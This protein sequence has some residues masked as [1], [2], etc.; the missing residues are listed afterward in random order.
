M[1]KE[2][3]AFTLIELL[4]VVSIIALLIAIL[5]PALNAARAQ[6]KK[7]ACASNL[8]QVGTA[9]HMYA[10][11]YRGTFPLTTHSEM[12]EKKTWIYTLK[13]YVSDVDEIR[14]CPADPQG[15][16]RLENDA[17]SYIFNEYLTPLYIFGMFQRD[18]SF[19]NLHRLDRPSRVMI[20]FECADD[21]SPDDTNSDHAHS[22]SWFSAPEPW[23]AIRADIQPDRHRAGQKSDDNTNGASNVLYGDIRVE[24][25]DARQL[26]DWADKGRNFA[27]PG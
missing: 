5:L 17:T 22:R 15:H 3:S 9:I 14:I 21:T 10:D 23:T 27:K 18:V 6:A 26:K 8:R 24:A 25:V 4:V 7:V 16:L 11:D 12:D 13:R 2:S 19:T 20:T 1:R